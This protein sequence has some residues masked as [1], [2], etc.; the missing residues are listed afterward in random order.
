M[1]MSKLGS[2]WSLPHGRRQVAGVAKRVDTEG[3]HGDRAMAS[4]FG[5]DDGEL[6]A[7]T[8][9]YLADRSDY[10]AGLGNAVAIL[11]AGIAYA[12]ATLA[13]FDQ[14]SSTLAPLLVALLPFPLWMVVLYHA[15]LGVAAMARGASITTLE[16]MILARTR[17]AEPVAQ[18]L[19][20][21]ATFVIFNVAHSAWPHRI[22]SLI[23]Y[24]GTGLVTVGY[25][26]YVLGRSGLFDHRWLWWPAGGYVGLSLVWLLVWVVGGQR[27]FS[28]ERLLGL[29]G[30]DGIDG[31]G[32]RAVPDVR[33][34]P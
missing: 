22:A 23:T 4:A 30:R 31:R 11:G 13:F 8:A 3:M 1:L 7:L 26:A 33:D 18:R 9:I 25:T 2:G 32:D 24:S 17:L 34:A 5:P 29:A 10:S 19:G 12:T 14:I 27:Y 15:L 6:E 21:R 20:F 28:S 16:R